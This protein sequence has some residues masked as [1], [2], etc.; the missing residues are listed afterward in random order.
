MPILFRFAY[1]A[2]LLWLVEFQEDKDKFSIYRVGCKKCN[3]LASRMLTE[4]D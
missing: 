3:Q 4:R 1:G 2:L